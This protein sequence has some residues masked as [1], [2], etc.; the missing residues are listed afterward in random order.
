MSRLLAGMSAQF[1]WLLID[2][3]PLLPIADAEVISWMADATIVVVRREK[4]SKTELKLALA[5]VA[6]S[7]L[8]GLLLN[9]FPSTAH[10]ADSKYAA[11]GRIS[12]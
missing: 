1:D 5:R 11:A 10:Y 7:K 8:I 2:S 4:T 6:P 3:V 9:D 12:G